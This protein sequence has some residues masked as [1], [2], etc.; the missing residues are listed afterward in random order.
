MVVV[1]IYL[2]RLTIQVYI[3]I[4]YKYIHFFLFA[5]MAFWISNWERWTP[6]NS[7]LSVSIC[8]GQHPSG[9]LLTMARGVRAYF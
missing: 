7:F 4:D 9:L 8:L 2:Y 6:A 3:S 5:T 1:N